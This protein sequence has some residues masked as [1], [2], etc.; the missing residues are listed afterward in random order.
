[1][2]FLGGGK[3]IH[4]FF[5]DT[6]EITKSTDSLVTTRK[7][8]IDGADEVPL[9]VLQNLHVGLSDRVEPHL[10]VHCGRHDAQRAGRSARAMALRASSARP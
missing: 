10:T 1:M 8:A 6:A 7:H 3:Q 5:H 4:R 9:V 2:T